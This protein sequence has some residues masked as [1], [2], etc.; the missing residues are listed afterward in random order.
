V[1]CAMSKLSGPLKALINA[2]HARPG[3]V[4][5]SKR[6]AALFNSIAR[7]AASK[8]VGLPA[9]LSISTAATMTMNS[10]ESLLELHRIATA[11]SDQ[12]QK[13][14]AAELMREVGLKCIS[15]NGIPR[16]IN[17]LGAF[18][19]GLA[20][21]ISSA[22]SHTP[23]RN[24]TESSLKSRLRHGIGLWKSIYHPFDEKLTAK[25]S[26]SHP[27]LPVHIHESHYAAL[28][29]NPPNTSN[30]S[31]SNPDQQPPSQR[32]GR[33]LT[34]LVGISCLRAQTGVGPQV[35]S[36]VFG[37]RKA[38]EDGSYE[39]DGEQVEGGKWLASD[40]GSV[41]ILETV[42]RI[43]DALGEGGGTTFA[44]GLKAKL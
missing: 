18:Y 7:D 22:M 24:L 23:S 19:T 27:D 14:S 42:D 32:V 10:P 15:F 9:W 16:S 34:S 13:V 26:Q 37:L 3:P 31:A 33:I 40:E 4:A 1:F 6:I 36:H 21:A 11:T 44:P 17:C 41:W 12:S 35:L 25:L 20:P 5:P 28:L 29:S 38:Y 2:P 43:V 8:G 39:A 30:T